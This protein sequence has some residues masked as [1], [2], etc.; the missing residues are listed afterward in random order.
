[1]KWRL[2]HI[3]LTVILSCTICVKGEVST[4]V[5]STTANSLSSPRYSFVDGGFVT[6]TKTGTGSNATTPTY[7]AY[8]RDHLGS[9][10]V[11]VSSTGAAEQIYHYYP[12]GSM[13]A[14]PSPARLPLSFQASPQGQRRLEDNRALCMRLTAGNMLGTAT[15]PTQP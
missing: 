12:Y 11:V 8:L 10:R 9:N 1:M 7:H 2:R 13:L 15:T 4:A 14:L 6:F 5:K 3:V